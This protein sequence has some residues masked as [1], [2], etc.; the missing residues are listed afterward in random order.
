MQASPRPCGVVPESFGSSGYS[1]VSSA[2]PYAMSCFPLP[3][4]S[5]VASPGIRV[6]E[7]PGS[8]GCWLCLSGRKGALSAAQIYRSSVASTVC[9][10]TP[11][12][13]T[14]FFLSRAQR[15][16]WRNTRRCCNPPV[17]MRLQWEL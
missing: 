14:L 2:D 13:E 4:A 7:R 3:V 10:P 6:H 17:L 15:H 1:Q 5:V 12:A 8:P 16:G 9:G 11:K